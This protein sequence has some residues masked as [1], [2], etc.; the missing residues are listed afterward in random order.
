MAVIWKLQR[1]PIDLMIHKWQMW[2]SEHLKPIRSAAPFYFYLFFFSCRDTRPALNGSEC[3]RRRGGMQQTRQEHICLGRFEDNFTTYWRHGHVS[4]K[5]SHEF[6]RFKKICWVLLNPCTRGHLKVPEW[7]C[8]T[9][10][11]WP[12]TL[13]ACHAY[14][15]AST[16]SGCS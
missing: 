3:E 2:S 13:R 15:W 11:G 12:L 9:A 16:H 1:H 8:L 7:R 5:G 14:S 6:P 10:C 4:S